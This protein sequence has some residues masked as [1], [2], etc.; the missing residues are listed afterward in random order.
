[1]VDT[2]LWDA[3]IQ[4]IQLKTPENITNILGGNLFIRNH[5]SIINKNYLLFKAAYVA[6]KQAIYNYFSFYCLCIK[7]PHL[8]NS[9]IAL[10]LK[11]KDFSILF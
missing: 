10:Q 11:S 7:I 5:Y 8:Q 6:S 1:M 9:N 2:F 3:Y 4:S